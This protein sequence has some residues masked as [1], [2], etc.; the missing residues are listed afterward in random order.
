MQRVKA[1]ISYDGGH[2]KGFQKQTSTKNTITTQ[3]EIALRSLGIHDTIK[4]SG[5]TDAGVHA[6]G[7]VIDFLL[8]DFWNNLDKLKFELNRKLKY[9]SFKHISY[10]EN[11]FHARFS[12]KKRVYRYIFK[13]S[14]PSIF[15][16][17]HVSYYP[18]FN[19]ELLKKSLDLFQG[20]H[21][22]SNFIKTGSITHTNIRH[23]YKAYYRP[24]NKYHI[25]YFEANGFLRSQ[26][27]MMVEASMQGALG[28]LSLEEIKEQLELKERYI[29]KLAPPEGLYLARITY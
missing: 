28:K 22:F 13:T 9:I 18:K 2:F 20:E 5:R 14:I 21:D 27:R 11:D 17:N 1:V 25:I 24:Y 26:V 19:K 8:P 12:A 6:T 15:E 16:Q 7:Q 29:T 23:I 4:G 3:I 10:I